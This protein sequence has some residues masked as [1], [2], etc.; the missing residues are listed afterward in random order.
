M[1]SFLIFLGSLFLFLIINIPIP[2]CLALA[3]LLL[4]FVSGL[5]LHFSL[6]V[7]RLYEGVDSFPLMAI[8]LFILTGNLMKRGGM[9]R[10]IVEV[11]NA[12]FGWLRG[13][14][15]FIT[16]ASCMFFA[17]MSGSA[18]A[19]A[20]AIGGIVLP[21]M[22]EKG[23]GKQFSGSL[24]ATAG[25]IGPI[26]PPSLPMV[27][28]GV[29]SGTSIAALFMG[30]VI[31]GLIIGLGL[32]VVAGYYSIKLG[33]VSKVPFSIKKAIIALKESFLTLG[34]PI[35]IVGGI[36]GGIFTP[37]ESA[38][39]A[40]VYSFVIGFFIYKDLKIKDFPRIMINTAISSAIVMFI[41]STSNFSAWVI[42]VKQIPLIVSDMFTYFSSTPIIVLIVIN[43]FL[44]FWGMI[45]DLTPSIMIL[46]PIFLPL[47]NELNIDLSYFG[48]IMVVNLCIGLVTPPVGT[49]LYVVSGM[50]GLKPLVLAKGAIPFLLVM[51]LVLLLMIIFPP[52]VT[53]LPS[54]VN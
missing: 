41:V 28:Y 4:M 18:V 46:V 8:P 54:L 24:L 39:V 6:I 52:I 12:L 51:V 29:T 48:V 43:I 20:S 17:G 40:A 47:L 27:I 33:Y 45:M 9:S 2:F 19:D 34:A 42:A 5:D 53:W 15:S 50:T 32:M 16:I 25:T 37:T 1:L 14:L 26:I 35:I 38:T 31:P 10:R 22:E 36:F 44:L 30:G 7:Q 11:A 21:I 49:V 13:S 23:Y 3:S